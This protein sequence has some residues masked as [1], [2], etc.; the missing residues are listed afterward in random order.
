MLR[1]SFLSSYDIFLEITALSF[2]PALSL[3]NKALPLTIIASTIFVPLGCLIGLASVPFF[4]GAN[5]YSA[6]CGGERSSP[7]F[8]TGEDNSLLQIELDVVGETGRPLFELVY[9]AS[10]TAEDDENLADDSE[11]APPPPPSY[12][13]FLGRRASYSTPSSLDFERTGKK[14]GIQRN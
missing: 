5:T 11:F 6:L 7:G 2:L 8:I 12:A 3:G 14:I 4:L 10:S 13:P 9:E 1:K